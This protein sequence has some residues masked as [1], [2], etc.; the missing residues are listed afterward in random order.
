[1]ETRL[2]L[3]ASMDTGDRDP[4]V[5]MPLPITIIRTTMTKR[6]TRMVQRAV[7]SLMRTTSKIGSRRV[8]EALPGTRARSSS[9]LTVFSERCGT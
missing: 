9:I 7:V 3:E 8:S 4:E 1:M 6:T 2:C 5:V